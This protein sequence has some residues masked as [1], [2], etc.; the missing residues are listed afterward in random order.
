M[1]WVG[2]NFKTKRKLIRYL[3]LIKINI[4]LSPIYVFG[5]TK[6]FYKEPELKKLNWN[7]KKSLRIYF[8]IKNRS[9]F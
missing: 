7:K 3:I 5:Y 9:L 4:N 8:K 6:E 1:V 2:F